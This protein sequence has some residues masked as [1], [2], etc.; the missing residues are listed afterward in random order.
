MR[1]EVADLAGEQWGLVTTAQA[2]AVGIS[3]PTMARLAR[4]GV[5]LRLEHGVYKI[6][7]SGYDP[8]DELRAA[9]LML[10]PKLT[11][12]QRISE[13]P[14]DAVISHRSAAR[15]LELGDL[16]ADLFEFTVNGRKQTRRKD[17]RI[18]IR[19]TDVPRDAWSLVDGLP[20]TTATRTIEDLAANQTDGGHLA[21]VVRDAVATAIVDLDRLS[22]VLRPY[23][24]RY[25]AP[26]GD[27]RSLIRRLLHEA[28]LPST[29]VQAVELLQQVG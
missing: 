14:L 9:W 27:G 3:G 20:V 13:Q 22:D 23:A 19:S 21:G 4:D 11:A 24:H 25:G 8:R 15:V 6:S 2:T 12:S 10:N 29:T 17:I 16:D 18:H 7:G 1:R 28:G 5:L 26:P